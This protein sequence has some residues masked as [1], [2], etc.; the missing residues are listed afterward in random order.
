MAVTINGKVYR[1]QQEQIYKNMEDIEELQKKIKDIYTTEAELTSSSV[2]V[3]ISDTNIGSAEEGYLITQDGLLFKIT[4]N[5]GTNALLSYYSD[6][7]GPQGEQGIPGA[8]VSIDDAAESLTKTWSSSKIATE[9]AAAGK[10]LY[11]HNI[12]YKDDDYSPTINF[13][14]Q[15]ENENPNAMQKADIYDYLHNNGF[16]GTS[17]YYKY[18]ATGQTQTGVIQGVMALEIGGNQTL[19]FTVGMSGAYNVQLGQMYNSKINDKVILK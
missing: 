7:K 9:L 16:D 4:G 11:Q 12:T 3:A 1:N 13:C 15:I 17:P 14:L 10:Q 8:A 18:F 2:S 5:D 19:Q 6:L